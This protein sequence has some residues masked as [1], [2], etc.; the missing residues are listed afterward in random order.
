MRLIWT[1][2]ESLTDNSNN[3][4]MALIHSNSSSHSTEN[5]TSVKIEG[6]NSYILSELAFTIPQQL[7]SIKEISCTPNNIVGNDEGKQ[8]C[9]FKPAGANNN[10]YNPHF[11]FVIIPQ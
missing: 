8:T 6:N 11:H 2:P 5:Y 9:M 10:L 4:T 1:V 7:N 3:D